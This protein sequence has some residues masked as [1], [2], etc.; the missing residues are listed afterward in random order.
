MELSNTNFLDLQL[1]FIE[2]EKTIQVEEITH[3]GLAILNLV[4]GKIRTGLGGKCLVDFEN[5]PGTY[6]TIR[7]Y[8]HKFHTGDLVQIREHSTQKSK[9]DQKNKDFK[10][11]IFEALV[12]TVK[13]VKITLS[14]NNKSDEDLPSSSKKYWIVKLA[15]N[16]I[17]KRMSDT[18]IRLKEMKDEEMTLLTKVLLEREKPSLPWRKDE[19]DSPISNFSLFDNTLNDGQKKAVEFSLASKEITVI[20]GPPG[21]GKTSTLIEI[22][23]QFV[24]RNKRLLVCGPSN[25]SVADN[26]VER[27]SKHK[28][29]LIRIGRPERLLPPI[30]SHSLDIV[31]KTSDQGKI[32]QDLRKEINDAL[33]KIGKARYKE[34]KAIY[35]EIKVLRKEYKEREKKCINDIIKES[36][37]ILST[38]HGAGEKCLYNEKFHVVIIDEAS[39]AL[40][41][42]SWIPLIN[43]EKVILAGDHLQLSPIIKAKLNSDSEKIVTTSLLERILKTHGDDIK[44]F[45]EIQYRMHKNICKFPSN[46]LYKGRLVPDK[47]VE[48]RLLKDLDGVNDTEETRES[49]VFYN[50]QG[51]YMY[52]SIENNEHMNIFSESKSNQMEASLVNEYVIKL[53][54]A[55][56]KQ[57]DIAVITP[58]SAQVS[59][60]LQILKEKYPQ[61]EI[62]TVDGFQGREKEAIIF[63]LVRSNEKGE[64]GFL[65]DKKRL[66]VA[67]TRPKR[68]LCIIG[69]S[70]TIERNSGFLKRWVQYLEYN[71][72]LRYPL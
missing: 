69:D 34:R 62:N 37:V 10:E 47:S 7:L 36:I 3:L 21:T 46:E 45:L 38:L 49:L 18:I 2:K 32:I 66:N 41:A 35:D 42:Q 67:I 40:E 33:K 56:V 59:L 57:E 12:L 11:N 13:D 17:F 58:Y 6:P 43:A 1:Q 50:T 9:T 26:I 19:K 23:R 52:E 53:I 20:H 29:P 24:F 68:H 16:H 55:G 25:V 71:S 48:N 4:P 51:A 22:I 61:I 8:A 5:G 14:V 63:S 28:I 31:V 30:L 64:V 39:Q 60:L 70:Q 72:D 15:N 65:V 54:N 44:C 27:L